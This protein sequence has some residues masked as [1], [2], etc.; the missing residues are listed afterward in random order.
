MTDKSEILGKSK[1][2]AFEMHVDAWN[3]DVK[4]RPLTL[5]EYIKTHKKVMGE[6][7]S[8]E[9]MLEAQIEAVSIALIDPKITAQELRSIDVGKVDGIVEIYERIAKTGDGVPKA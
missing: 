2:G 1:P 4:V 8:I 3:A 7:P 5:S 9:D 6:A